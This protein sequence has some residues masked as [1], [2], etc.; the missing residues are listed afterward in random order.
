MAVAVPP[1]ASHLAQPPCAVPENNQRLRRPARGRD[2]R[3]LTFQG[4]ERRLVQR[5]HG[6]VIP[7]PR[8]PEPDAPPTGNV[9]EKKY[10]KSKRRN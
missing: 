8:R 7:G 9:R 3:R 6:T 5:G 1:P 10:I 2:R 4:L